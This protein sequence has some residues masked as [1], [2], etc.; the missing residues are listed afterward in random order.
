[1]KF[2]VEAEAFCAFIEGTTSALPVVDRLVTGRQ[3][4]LALYTEGLALPTHP[5][6]G[7]D[8]EV[9]KRMPRDWPGFEQHDLYWETFDPAEDNLVGSSLTDDLLDVYADVSRGLDLW[10]AGHR[11]EAVWAW[12]FHLDAHWGAHAID[13]LRALHWTINR[14]R[15]HQ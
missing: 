9:P 1:M 12:R 7:I 10:N 3:R 14:V 8:R 13:A 5:E 11:I 4:L 2:V 6:S 15:G